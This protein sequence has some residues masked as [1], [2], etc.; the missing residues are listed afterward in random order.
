VNEGG[1]IVGLETVDKVQLAMD[2]LLGV[3]EALKSG[4][5]AFRGIRE[6]YQFMTGDVDCTFQNGGFMQA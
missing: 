1:V 5:K 6:A 2:G 3:K 4:V